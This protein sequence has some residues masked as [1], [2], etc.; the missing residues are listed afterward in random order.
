[1]KM[2]STSNETQER[3]SM[4]PWYALRTFNCQ[5]QKVSQFLTSRNCLHFVPMAMQMSKTD[6]SKPILVPA[7][8]N[9][10]FIQKNGTQQEIQQ[11]LNE[12]SIPVRIFRQP[13][14]DTFC[15]IPHR[16]MLE[17]RMLC[18]PKFSTSI[19]LTPDEAEMMVGKEVR[20]V[21]GPFKGSTGRLIRKNKK[22]YFL[23]AF[24]GMGIMIRISRWYCKPL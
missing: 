4:A 13:G 21:A 9:L 20:I 7:I 16:E 5:E 10:L 19:Y 2:N 15:E 18:D 17:L 22:F 11:V 24:I 12:C 6:S 3:S 23:K 14:Q 1:M 8:H